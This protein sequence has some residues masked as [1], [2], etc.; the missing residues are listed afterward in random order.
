MMKL[1]AVASASAFATPLL[2]LVS[3]LSPP[4]GYAAPTV[5]GAVV[6]PY[7]TAAWPAWMSLDE[8]SGILYTGVET[9]PPARI[10]RIADGGTPY[11]GYGAVPILDPDAVLH[12]GAGW[13]S[14]GAGAVLVAA[15][16]AARA[17]G[18]I[19]PTPPKPW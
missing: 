7:A 4:A 6:E 16:A 15:G 10:W 19:S 8:T 14:G 2:T 12:D 1:V 18:R 11:A 5:P 3:L 13:L 17:V 9:G